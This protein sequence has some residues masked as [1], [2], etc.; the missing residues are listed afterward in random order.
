MAKPFDELRERLLRAGVAPRHA[1][2]YLSELRDHM[3]DLKD[4]EKN[5]GRSLVDAEAAALARLG[6]IDALAEAMIEQRQFQSWSARAPWTMFTLAPLLLLAVAYYVSLLVLWS[7][8]QIF[9]PGADTPFARI[10]GFAVFYLGLGRWIYFGAPVFAG[11]G[12]LIIAARQRFNAL[13]PI[14]GTAL[15]AFVA[16]AAQVHASRTAMPGGL[17]HI[18]MDFGLPGSE[19]LLFGRL[20][21]ALV[22]L[23]LAWAPYIVWRLRRAS[24]YRTA[25][26]IALMSGLSLISPAQSHAQKLEFDVASIRSN[27][28]NDR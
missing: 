14:A 2:R 7:G 15:V 16:A 1:R 5:V 13:W 17:G 19:L 9:L 25:L 27:Q 11:W 28:S 23:S 22:I 3:S 18:R 21:Y 24:L 10:D 4:E 8:W 6:S 26:T 12:I 20:V